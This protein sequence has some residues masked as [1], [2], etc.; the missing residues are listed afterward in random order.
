M[1]ILG[2]MFHSTFCVALR[3]DVL[4]MGFVV[5]YDRKNKI[6]PIGWAQESEIGEIWPQET[7]SYWFFM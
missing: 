2:Y 4:N 3:R 5:H 1:G 6:W 7:F